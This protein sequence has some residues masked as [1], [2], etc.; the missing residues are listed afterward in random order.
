MRRPAFDDPPPR[1]T[2]NLWLRGGAILLAAWLHFIA[3]IVLG[4]IAT[5]EGTA[6]AEEPAP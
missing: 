3:S 6:P 4:W 1:A 2:P 5:R